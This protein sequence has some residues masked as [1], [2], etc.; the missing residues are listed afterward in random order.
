MF[1]KS[2]WNRCVKWWQRANVVAGAIHR[3]R[4]ISASLW[5]TYV[6]AIYVFSFCL[7]G[8]IFC[9]VARAMKRTAA[10]RYPMLYTPHCTLGTPLST[11]HT[12]TH[13]IITFR[14]SLSTL[15]K[16]H[17]TLDTSY[18]TFLAPHFILHTPHPKL[19]TP[20]STVYMIREQWK[21]ARLL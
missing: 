3:E 13:Y 1:R 9:E 21:N 7:A 17:S 12:P 8:A 14:A 18:S 20:H 4:L 2:Q 5:D 15:H 10:T 6:F 11:L 19:L 16:A